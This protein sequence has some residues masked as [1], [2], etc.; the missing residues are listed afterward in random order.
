MAY[1][2]FKYLVDSWEFQEGPELVWD[3]EQ[4]L[5]RGW[6]EKTV[7]KMGLEGGGKLICPGGK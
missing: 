1:P 2:V 7:F 4:F 3:V 5:K 6:Y